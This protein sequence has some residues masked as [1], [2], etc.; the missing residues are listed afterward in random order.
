VT[1]LEHPKK[2]FMKECVKLANEAAKQ[3]HYP[4]AC[5]VVD[6]TGNVISSQ[7]SVLLN[8]FDPTAHPEVLA[9]RAATKKRSS[10]YIE[11]CFLYT[12]LEPCPMCTSAAIWAKM[13]GIVFGANQQDALKYSEEHP[14]TV[15]TFRQILIPSRLIVE[16]GTPKLRLYEN[17]MR[18][19]CIALFELT[20]PR[21]H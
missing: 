14:S 12:T 15:Y 20:S 4:I 5:L 6:S 17:F 21:T 18:K 3:G 7:K 19:E 16:R 13:S 1:F 9:I 10:R 2:E 11:D 8:T